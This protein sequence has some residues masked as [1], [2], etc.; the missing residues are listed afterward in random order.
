MVREGHSA[1]PSN[2]VGP[3]WGRRRVGAPEWLRGATRVS[4]TTHLVVHLVR[5]DAHRDGGCASFPNHDV[6][7]RESLGKYQ[8]K[9]HIS[10]PMGF[11]DNSRPRP[12]GIEVGSERDQPL[13]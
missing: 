7:V 11:V 2:G 3:K 12:F 10:I 4:R 9:G 6:T 5:R 8:Q 1:R 13:G